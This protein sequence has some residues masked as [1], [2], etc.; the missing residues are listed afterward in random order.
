MTRGPQGREE[1]DEG[2][3]LTAAIVLFSDFFAMMKR[4]WTASQSRIVCIHASLL[5][6]APLRTSAL[7]CSMTHARR[8]FTAWTSASALMQMRK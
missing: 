8:V 4:P 6:T 1:K 3:K 7:S 2:A 5:G